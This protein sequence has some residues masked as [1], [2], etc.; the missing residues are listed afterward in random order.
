M[1]QTITEPAASERSLRFS[2]QDDARLARAKRR[3]AA[4]KGFYVHLFIFALV[5]TGLFAINAASGGSWWALWVLFGW[6][7]GVVVHALAV[8][9]RKPQA[10][11]AWEERKIR[12]LANEP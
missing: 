5:L 8:F 3:V 4:I 7:I 9:G 11:A 1:M 2:A 12:Q 6:G 10:V